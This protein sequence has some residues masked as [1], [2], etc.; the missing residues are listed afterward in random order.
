M[1]VE[2]TFLE[3]GRTPGLVTAVEIMTSKM[4]RDMHHH[5]EHLRHLSEVD[6]EPWSPAVYRAEISYQQSCPKASSQHI[7]PHPVR[8]QVVLDGA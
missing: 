3:R 1:C 4:H 8:V 6:F 7:P 5:Q 2:Q